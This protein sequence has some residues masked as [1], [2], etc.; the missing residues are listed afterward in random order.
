MARVNIFLQKFSMIAPKVSFHH[1]DLAL[2][3]HVIKCYILHVRDR[4]YIMFDPNIYQE[5]SSRFQTRLKLVFFVISYP[6]LLSARV[7]YLMVDFAG[8]IAIDIFSLTLIAILKFLR[9]SI[10]LIDKCLRK[11]AKHLDYISSLINNAFSYLIDYTAQLIRGQ[12]GDVVAAAFLFM[13]YKT[14]FW[15]AF[16][17]VSA[18]AAVLFVPPSL[19][20]FVAYPTW[21]LSFNMAIRFVFDNLV[22]SLFRARD[23]AMDT[24]DVATAIQIRSKLIL[25]S[26]ASVTG[27]TK[28]ILMLPFNIINYFVTKYNQK[29]QASLLPMPRQTQHAFDRLSWLSQE[30]KQGLTVYLDPKEFVDVFMS[31]TANKN[32]KEIFKYFVDRNVDSAGN[33]LINFNDALKQQFMDAKNIIEVDFWKKKRLTRAQV[34]AISA[35]QAE[36]NDCI[37][38]D[39]IK[40]PIIITIVRPAANSEDPDVVSVSREL[41]L[42]EV[43][44]NMYSRAERGDSELDPKSNLKITSIEQITFDEQ[45]FSAIDSAI[46]NAKWKQFVADKDFAEFMN[47]MQENYTPQRIISPGQMPSFK[48][49]LE[50]H[51]EMNNAR[52]VQIENLDMPIYVDQPTLND[53]QRTNPNLCCELSGRLMRYPVKLNDHH[54][55]LLELIYKLSRAELVGINLTSFA[56]IEVDQQL[57]NEIRIKLQ[58]T[59]NLAPLQFSETLAASLQNQQFLSSENSNPK[60]NLNQTPASTLTLSFQ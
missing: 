25:R 28:S 21:Y 50:W 16:S 32:I 57:T 11:L 30:I 18:A 47:Y 6:F 14:I 29:L 44:H 41:D 46:T 56:Q 54:Y 13:V 33:R 42:L 17:L 52:N 38:F 3:C 59:R 58:Q 36:L 31:A 53:I 10:N 34:D 60:P 24:E 20:A 27:F 7:L 8:Y 48:I 23:N 35:A 15:R 39:L 9:T 49:D 55:D 2:T 40:C 26:V 5:S 12:L 45:K 19:L 1:K 37:M 22:I 51:V 4:K 43:L